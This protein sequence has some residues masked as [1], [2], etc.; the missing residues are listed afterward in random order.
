[1]YVNHDAIDGSPFDVVVALP[2][3]TPTKSSDSDVNAAA[4]PVRDD[5]VA[6]RADASTSI[7][8]GSC[9]RVVH[10]IF[11]LDSMFVGH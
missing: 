4:D 10:V 6:L 1:V 8:S 9:M 5:D 11:F 2:P 7:V 3:S